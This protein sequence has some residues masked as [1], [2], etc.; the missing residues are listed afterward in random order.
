MSV[1][2]PTR[3]RNR[4]VASEQPTT[5]DVTDDVTRRREFRH[6]IDEVA[7]TGRAAEALDADVERVLPQLDD[8]H[9]HGDG[10][11]AELV[12]R[13]GQWNYFRRHVE[14]HREY[15]QRLSMRQ[16]A[17]KLSCGVRPSVCLSV[18][19]VNCV[20][21]IELIIKQL[22]LDCPAVCLYVREIALPAV[23]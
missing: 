19:R 14:I 4:L 10:V 15:R 13:L 17:F 5:D 12:E 21:R 2:R 20:D 11:A 16:N 1:R 22:A 7:D 3:Q 23:M 18:T 8:R 9:H 6:V